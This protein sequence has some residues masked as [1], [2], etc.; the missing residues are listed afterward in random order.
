MRAHR[1]AYEADGWGVGEIWLDG[2]R[3]LWHE[4]P[5]PGAA[6]GQSHPLGERFAAYFTGKRDDFRDLEL[7]V[8]DPTPFQRSVLEVLRRIPY[9]ETVT[10]GELAALAGH[11]NAQRAAGTFCAH[12]RFA[13]VVPCHRVVAAEG[14]GSYGSLG[15]EYKRRLLELEGVA[16]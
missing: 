10:Y 2:D 16:L 3:M 1:V 12:N 6:A 4:L 9:G 5:R 15:V 7:E 11:P 13:I 8:D 14:L